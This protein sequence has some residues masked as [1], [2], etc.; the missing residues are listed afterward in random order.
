MD[1]RTHGQ[2]HWKMPPWNGEEGDSKQGLLLVKRK[3]QFT[4]SDVPS[5]HSTR[6]QTLGEFVFW[7]RLW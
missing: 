1:T 2:G 4:N 6:P 7:K 3:S 5:H